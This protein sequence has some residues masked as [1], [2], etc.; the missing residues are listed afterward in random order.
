VCTMGRANMIEQDEPKPGGVRAITDEFIETTK[1]PGMT[2]IHRNTKPA[3]KALWALVYIVLICLFGYTLAIALMKYVQYPKRTEMSKVHGE[4]LEFPAVTFCMTTPFAATKKVINGSEISFPGKAA[5]LAKMDELLTKDA[6]QS[7]QDDILEFKERLLSQEFMNE[8]LQSDPGNDALYHQLDDEIIHCSLDGENCDMNNFDIFKH[9]R[10]GNCFMFNGTKQSN[11]SGH[12]IHEG[13]SLVIFTNSYIPGDDA[14]DFSME[15][16]DATNGVKMVIH[17]KDIKTLLDKGLDLSPGNQFNIGLSVSHNLRLPA[18]YGMCQDSMNQN[19]DACKNECLQKHF[20][21]QCTC[22]SPFAPIP[23]N[24]DATEYCGSFD[25]DNIDSFKKGLKRLQCEKDILN[26]GHNDT[27]CDCMAPC[28]ETTY[29]STVRQT[30]WPHKNHFK[31]FLKTTLEGNV[32]VKSLMELTRNYANVTTGD[33]NDTSLEKDLIL[34]NFLKVNIKFNS[35][36]MTRIVESAAYTA[37]ALVMDVAL[38]LV[39]I[40]GLSLIPLV[41]MLVYIVHVFWALMCGRRSNE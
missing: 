4:A 29:S 21:E 23:S 34:E 37:N 16:T 7:I 17:D 20:K 22:L 8:N 2:Q 28:S 14:L 32:A 25:T 1:A 27:G 35:F 11:D 15:S 41:H 10:Y 30:P 39:I 26:E 40:L 19:H 24:S 12:A 5:G 9:P 38:N 13:L 3:G 33:Y 31:K 36:E 18:P 6:Y